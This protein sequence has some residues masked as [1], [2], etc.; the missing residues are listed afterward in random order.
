MIKSYDLSIRSL[1][2]KCFY[3]NAVAISFHS[4]GRRHSKNNWTVLTGKKGMNKRTLPPS[5]GYIFRGVVSPKK[6][7]QTRRPT[8][9]VLK[10]DQKYTA[11]GIENKGLFIPRN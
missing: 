11:E 6:R 10:C 1:R 9:F 4:E 2:L 7:K 3:G 8:R 5:Q